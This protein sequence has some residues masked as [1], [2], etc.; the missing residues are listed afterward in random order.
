VV[1]GSSKQGK[2]SLRKKTLMDDDYIIV[3]CTRNT[4]KESINET[5]LKYAGASISNVKTTKRDVGKKV[6]ASISL[7]FTIPGV[8]K[9]SGGAEAGGDSKKTSELAEQSFEINVSDPNDICRVLKVANF[10]KYIVL[11]D[12]H[13][14]PDSVQESL[15]YDLKAYHDNSPYIFIIIGVWLESNKLVLYNG[16]LSY[17]LNTISADTWTDDNLLRVLHAGE[18][19]LNISFTE[20]TKREMLNC[21][22]GNVGL[23]QEMAYRLCEEYKINMTQ[24]ECIGVGEA[25][26]VREVLNLISKE[27]APRYLNFIRE[28]VKETATSKYKLSAWVLKAI[29]ANKNTIMKSGLELDQIYTFIKKQHAFGFKIRRTNVESFLRKCDALQHKHKIQPVVVEYA[30]KTLR[31]TDV[32]FMVFLNMRYVSEI[33]KMLAP[34][35]HQQCKNDPLAAT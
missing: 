21:A 11:E 35:C 6:K 2:T 25:I 27:E 32:N 15:A 34:H 9:A 14:L 28:F 4:T 5:I 10:N 8:T 7:D 19:L 3:Q 13:Y 16:D 22:H 18:A 17:R 20:E 24:S 30:H 1:H 26:D 33:E 23:L 29:L 31:I 12:F